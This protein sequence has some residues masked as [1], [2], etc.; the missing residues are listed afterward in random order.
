MAM[1]TSKG[2]SPPKMMGESVLPNTQE[3]HSPRDIKKA[4]FV[5]D[6]PIHVSRDGG[7]SHGRHTIMRVVGGESH[8]NLS[9]DASSGAQ[10]FDLSALDPPTDDKT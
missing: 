2:F 8:G 5:D 10:V 9:G 4:L 1:E 3:E 6:D 7:E